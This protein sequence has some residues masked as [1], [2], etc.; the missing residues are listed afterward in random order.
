[1][2][3]ISLPILLVLVLLSSCKRG[4]NTKSE[5]QESSALVEK[6]LAKNATSSTPKDLVG[7]WKFTYPYPSVDLVE[8]HY[9]KIE[10]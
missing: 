9:M 8:D 5:I 7:L 2:K 1:M 10:Q 4:E 6:P 3:T